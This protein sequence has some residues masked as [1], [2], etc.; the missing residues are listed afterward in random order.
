MTAVPTVSVIIPTYNCGHFIG[1]GLESVM[2]QTYQH[3]EVI[4]VDDGS[5]DETR[6]CVEA[7]GPRVRYIHQ[8][9]AGPSAAR[10][11]GI[12]ASRGTFLA[13]L[14]ADDV[15]LP[16]KLERQVAVMEADPEIGVVYTWWAHVDETGA[17]LPQTVQPTHHG[18]VF[19]QLL[20]GCFVTPAM[21]LIRRSC[22][23]RVGLF[24]TGMRRGEDWD[25]LLRIAGARY[26][27]A[28]IPEI[29]MQYR[30]HA[31]QTSGDFVKMTE[32]GRRVLAKAL[33][34]LPPDALRR[35]LRAEAYRNLY[36]YAASQAGERGDVTRADAWLAKAMR[37]DPGLSRRPGFYLAMAFNLLPHGYRTTGEL[38]TRLD[39]VAAT[40][41]SLSDRLLSGRG[42]PGATAVDKRAAF[43]AL[44][45]ALA[46]L[47]A[48]CGRWWQAVS[49]LGR[50]LAAHPLTVAAAVRRGAAGHWR[51]VRMSL[52]S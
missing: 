33:A 41:S 50:S 10:N 12:R 24:D 8:S 20:R 32:S 52:P 34:Q 13:F 31:H 38:R 9:N 14:D 17:P 3:I 49:S 5:T 51:A 47:Y 16:R 40:L 21:S 39:A 25:L 44:H 27:F 23:D 29:L 6:R 46:I 2:A 30:L 45:L 18:H 11:T 26:V 4:V 1:T 43:S 35:R 42:L 36:A 7:F 37:L 22:L 28:C 19:E 48:R 15:W